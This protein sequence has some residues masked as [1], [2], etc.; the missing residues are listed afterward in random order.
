MQLHKV[1]AREKILCK[2][3]FTNPGSFFILS[4]LNTRAHHHQHQLNPNS[5]NT[6]PMDI[7]HQQVETE[8]EPTTSVLATGECLEEEE[9]VRGV[10][11]DETGK[12]DSDDSEEEEEGREGGSKDS[13]EED[14]EEEMKKE[15]KDK[16]EVADDDDDSEEDSEEG[17]EEDSEEESEGE[18]EGDD[19]GENS[20]E[21]GSEIEAETS[22]SESDEDL[23]I[24]K[25]SLAVISKEAAIVDIITKLTSKAFHEQDL[26]D[27]LHQIWE[28]SDIGLW[29]KVLRAHMATLVPYLKTSGI[30]M[31]MFISMSRIG[32]C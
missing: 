20:E 23:H 4:Q 8:K 22:S 25:H 11:R 26:F 19:S 6:Q 13:E 32:E 18:S 2:E 17:S 1:K 28:E 31:D 24:Y 16:M 5:M 12:E 27:L 21:E 9:A 7:D 10:Q 15:S 14:D 29:P 3:Y 30:L